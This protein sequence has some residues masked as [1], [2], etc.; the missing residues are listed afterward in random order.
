ML[1]ILYLLIILIVIIILIK[2]HIDI[3]LVIFTGSI[4][5]AILFRIGV[6]EFF[7]TFVQSVSSTDTLTLVGTVI[8]IKYFGAL[9]EKRGDLSRMMNGFNSLVPD[10]RLSLVIPS[11]VIGLL[12]MP[13][14]ALVS[15]P[16]VQ[17]SAITFGLKPAQK[18]FLN[19]WFRHV[20][21][22]FWP[23]YPGLILTSTIIGVPIFVIARFQFPLSLVAILAG[24][25]FGLKRI[26][27]KEKS[28]TTKKVDGL[29][30]LLCSTW[31]LIIIITLVLFFKINVLYI[32]A[33]V[34]VLV[35]LLTHLS[36]DAWKDA[37]KQAFDY[38]TIILLFSVM[39]FKSILLNT[40]AINSIT[41]GLSPEGCSLWLLLF[42]APFIVGLLTGINHAYVGVSFSILLPFFLQNGLN[43]PY[44]MF[45]YASGFAGVLLSPVHLCLVLTKEY[46]KAD[47]GKIY[48]HLIPPV[49][50]VWLFALLML[51]LY[52][53]LSF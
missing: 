36:K 7:I 44:I 38:R 45:S 46:F 50:F 39:F 18:T 23:L 20:W 22:Y 26:P 15:A 31:H 30:N 5:A 34:S 19:Y 42:T 1:P 35:S 51:F 52:G 29:K 28:S 3:G 33:G 11:S 9:L 4:L 13:G 2:F 41:G 47:F 27:F 10:N 48:R 37:I 8:F 40:G 43:L 17:Q 32:M 49:V 21:E 53:K 16:M 24:L 6:K 25:I 14:G 12:P